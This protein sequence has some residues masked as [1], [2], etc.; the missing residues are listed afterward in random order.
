MTRA[1]RAP[2]CQLRH[3]CGI[4]P[5]IVD[6]RKS[7]LRRLVPREVDELIDRI[8]K[9]VGTFGYDPWGY[10]ADDLKLGLSLAR[11]LY[12]HYFRVVANGLENIPVEGRALVIA[13][14]SG[15]LP[16][17]GLLIGMAIATNPRGPR[18]ARAMV[19]R[20]LP[21]VPYVGNLLNAWG[22]VLGDPVN[23][24]RLL[25]R[26]EVVIVFPEGVRGSGKPY[27]DRYQLQRFGHGFMHIAMTH[28]A[29]IIPVGVV[30]C[31]ETIPSAGNFES[32]AR[33][34][35]APY[36]PIAVP[37]PL[38]AR[39]TL[40]FGEPMYFDGDVANE[41]EVHDRVEQVKT[42]LRELIDRGLSERTS[43][44]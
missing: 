28:R 22:A 11:W 5:H 12:E 24:I 40:N 21:T 17:D 6:R 3:Q 7:W 20:F 43:I 39:V 32:L 30:G 29:P 2:H 35:K 23:C 10:H 4:L 36:I 27:R 8:P 44:F 37:F 14:H 38:P 33:L 25:K 34:L 19:E 41:D 15:Q 1:R 16:I 13:N 18:A 9:P 31:E 42:R 26:E